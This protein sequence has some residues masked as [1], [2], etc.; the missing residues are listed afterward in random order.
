[1]STQAEADPFLVFSALIQHF[2]HSSVYFLPCQVSP[3]PPTTTALRSETD[4]AEPEP[5]I[6]PSEDAFIKQE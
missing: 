4:S 3:P 6:P 5:V 2:W 1:M